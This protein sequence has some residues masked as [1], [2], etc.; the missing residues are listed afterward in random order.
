MDISRTIIP[1]FEARHRIDAASWGTMG[2]AIPACFASKIIEP[3]KSVVAVLGDSSFGFSAMELET[4]TRYGLDLTVFVI[5]NGGIGM[6]VAEVPKSV[7]E[8]IPN[9]L[10][11]KA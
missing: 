1:S 11:W 4:C 6:G 2:Q 8:I 3:S 7:G 9:Q 5:N 10:N